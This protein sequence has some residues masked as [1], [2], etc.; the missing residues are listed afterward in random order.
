MCWLSQEKYMKR[1]HGSLE[2]LAEHLVHHALKLGT[3]DNVT[4]VQV[5]LPPDP[6]VSSSPPSFFLCSV[7]AGWLF[8]CDCR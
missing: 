6:K 1:N 2:G 8:S 4:V 3:A 7:G 5:P